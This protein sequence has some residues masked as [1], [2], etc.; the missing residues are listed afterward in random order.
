MLVAMPT[1]LDSAHADALFEMLNDM[2]AYIRPANVQRLQRQRRQRQRLQ[3]RTITSHAV[4]LF[5]RML[6]ALLGLPAA[7]SC[8]ANFSLAC[9]AVLHRVMLHHVCY[10]R[11]PSLVWTPGD[12][13]ACCYCCALSLARTPVDVA[14]CLLLQRP[15]AGE[16]TG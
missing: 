6:Q 8:R 13:A 4:A 10:C 7:M 1:E 5:N 9:W 11:T 12:A 3:R 16:D 14:A 2:L 15:V